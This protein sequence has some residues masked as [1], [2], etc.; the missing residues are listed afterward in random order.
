MLSTNT[1]I[2][3]L[4]AVRVKFASWVGCVED[5]CPAA[6]PTTRLSRW[7][8][9]EYY[10]LS[11][12]HVFAPFSILQEFSS[13]RCFTFFFFQYYAF[14]SRSFDFGLHSPI[15]LVKTYM[16]LYIYIY[17]YYS[18]C[19]EWRPQHLRFN[20]QWVL[21]NDDWDKI[22]VSAQRRVESYSSTV[23]SARQVNEVGLSYESL[24]RHMTQYTATSAEQ[25]VFVEK[26]TMT[27]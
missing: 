8:S 10:L 19:Q 26:D 3:V 2:I 4:Q 20:I 17:M 24:L 13:S 16:Y 25:R 6:A 23:A 22:W 1:Q 14:S 15:L 27:R 12:Q 7:C 11:F 21:Q 18:A 5:P 9:V